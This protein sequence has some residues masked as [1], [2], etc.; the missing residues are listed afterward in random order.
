MTLDMQKL[1]KSVIDLP[2]A[3]GLEVEAYATRQRSIRVEVSDGE[4]ET[5][6]EA[7]QTG[8]GIRV[9]DDGRLGLAFT[10]NLGKT[11]LLN[12]LKQAVVNA[13]SASSDQHNVL[14]SAKQTKALEL[15]DPSM[16][17]V[18]I[19]SKIGLAKAVEQ[20]ARSRD[21]RIT[22]VR[23]STYSDGFYEV[24]IANTRGVS[25][26]YEG[27]Y[28]A[29]SVMVIAEANG[30]AEMGWS[31]DFSRVFNELDPGKIGE[32]AADKAV[33]MLGAGQVETCRVPV[34]FAPDI[35]ADFLQVLAPAL[36]GEAVQK[37]KSL[38]A[39]RLGEQVGSPVFTLVDS[40]LL[41]DGLATAP[42]DDEGTPSQRTVVIEQGQLKCYL[43]NA[44][45]A[46]R[47][48]VESTGNGVRPSFKGTVGTGPRNFYL[49]P[50]N[51]SQ[52]DM[53]AQIERGMLITQ[54][55]G[56]HTAN[57]ISGEFSVGA[58][59]L[60]IEQGQI[61]RPVRGVAIAGNL[62]DFLKHA[63]VVGSDLRFF[64]STGSPSL[65]VEGITIS[66]E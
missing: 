28:G 30:Q 29:A 55:M 46:A 8:I 15:L 11:D 49:E 44:Q 22:K 37:D 25:V 66:G 63:A 10:T 17:D 5:L 23:Q 45:S 31:F 52:G 57:P 26:G 42:V 62:S 19:E 36:T 4:V 50:G 38:F 39:G 2:L 56:M 18:S 64:G 13:E 34:I 27:A 16:L 58:S 60:W 43:Y 9:I 1:A 12:T 24:G 33:Q 40:G 21:S 3:R 61:K 47:D 6:R 53:I 54:V 20:A 59:G 51:V 41:P 48:Q 14:P 35:A 65:L 32:E 7:A